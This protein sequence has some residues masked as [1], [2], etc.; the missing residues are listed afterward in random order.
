MIIFNK[1]SNKASYQGAGCAFNK[2]AREVCEGQQM[3][4]DF[5]SKE[6]VSLEEYLLM[7]ELKTSVLLAS[8]QTCKWEQ[9]LVAQVKATE[10][11]V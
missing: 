10:T 3:D 9:Y 2:T 6:N 4:M 7:I 11:F 5:E 8:F 1:I